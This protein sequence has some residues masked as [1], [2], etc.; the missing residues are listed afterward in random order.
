MALFTKKTVEEEAA[1]AARKQQRRLDTE[2][3]KRVEGLQKAH[4]AFLK[5]PAGLARAAR[6]AGQGFFEIEMTLHQSTGITVLDA[7]SPKDATNGQARGDALTSIE[8]E[9]W[10][11]ENVGYVFV[12]TGGKTRDMMIGSGE[13]HDVIGHVAGIYLFRAIEPI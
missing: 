10:R 12:E 5:S 1:E 2:E 4:Q 3:R 11:L 7:K 6:Q 13:V 9:G 8:A